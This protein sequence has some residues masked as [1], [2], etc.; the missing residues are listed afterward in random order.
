MRTSRSFLYKFG[1]CTVMRAQAIMKY[2][3]E[4]QIKFLQL[5]TI[6]VSEMSTL[7]ILVC[8]Q[9]SFPISETDPCASTGS[10]S[11]E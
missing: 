4:N 5:S 10:Q 8:L 2:N 6:Q 1:L 11:L 3:I 7:E 9:H